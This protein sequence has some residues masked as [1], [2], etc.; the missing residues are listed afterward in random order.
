[1]QKNGTNSVDLYEKDG[2]INYLHEWCCRN[3][4][5]SATDKKYAY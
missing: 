1:M 2:E 5:R 3:T 4:I